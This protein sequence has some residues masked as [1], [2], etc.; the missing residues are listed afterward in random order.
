VSNYFQG[1]DPTQFQ[2]FRAPLADVRDVAPY[3]RELFKEKQSKELQD[4]VRQYEVKP[5][6]QVSEQKISN[7]NS[8]NSNNNLKEQKMETV[9]TQSAQT[10]NASKYRY[11]EAMINWDQLKNFGLSRENLEKQG[12][13]DGMLKG[14][15]TNKL[16][17]IQCNFGSATLKTDARLSF[18]QSP[19]GQVVLVMHGMRKE[20]ELN[21]PYFGH[22]FSDEDKKNLKETG[23]MGRQAMI[24]F[25]GSG[26]KI[27]YLI[28]IDKLTN[29]VV[30]IAASRAY[31]P[32]EIS[33]V[34]L[35]DYEKSE[36]R[37]GKAIFVEGM[38]GKTGKAFDAHLQLNAEKR[39]LEYI[40]PN[41]GQFNRESIGGV[42]LTKK[43]LE[44]LTAGKAIF[45]E[46]MKKKDGESFSAFVKMNETGNL[47]YTRYNPDSPEGNREIYIPKEICGVRLTPEDKDELR[48]G[49]PVFLY[50]MVNRKGENFNSWV[51]IDKE[52]G[53]ISYSKTQDGFDEK[54]AYKIPA[55]VW[56]VTLKSTERAQLQDGKAVYIAD[57]TGFNG[58]QFSSWVR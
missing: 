25:P 32:D 23:N 28:S 33:S 53:K 47:S 49:K 35:T 4:F 42:E 38:V 44:D 58:K 22:I 9:Q 45:L 19:E 6:S 48:A 1:K 36:L 54:P 39:G 29:E 52:T 55:E 16:V 40:F 11:N 21:K 18:Q 5:V 24:T 34:K 37:E 46:D 10:D 7:N 26:E 56:G 15:K 2:L 13:L 50:D 20:P 8:N 51:K 14:Y 43:Q 3:I 57:M 31:I 12:L 41:D 27:P 30:G 17:P